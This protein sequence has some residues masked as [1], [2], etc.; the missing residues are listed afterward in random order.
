MTNKQLVKKYKA[1]QSR[2]SKLI[3]WLCDHNMGHMRPSDMRI[4][5]NPCVEVVEYLKTLD[6][7]SHLKDEAQRRYGSDL[8]FVE[9]LT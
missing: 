7:L 8:Q 9:Y 6:E 2:E 3:D 4:L 1:L 5:S